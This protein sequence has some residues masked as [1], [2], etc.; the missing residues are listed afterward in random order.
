VD[1]IKR[2]VGKP[3]L[4]LTLPPRLRHLLPPGADTLLDKIDPKKK[5][6]AKPASTTNA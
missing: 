2:I 1:A 3:V 5:P 4:S 6:G